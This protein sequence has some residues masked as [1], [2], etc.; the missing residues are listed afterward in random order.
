M[1]KE[2]MV[3][4]VFT[5]CCYLLAIGLSLVSIFNDLYLSVRILLWFCVFVFLIFGYT[6][7]MCLVN[8]IREQ[9]RRHKQGYT[10]RAK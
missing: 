6:F 3:P 2:M 1:K 5:V 9:K 4:L 10:C 8:D 7:T